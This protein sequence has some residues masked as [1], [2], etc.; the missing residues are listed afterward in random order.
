MKAEALSAAETERLLA[1][2]ATMISAARPYMAAL[3]RAAG[4]DRHAAMLGDARGLVLDVVGDRESVH[5]PEAVPGPGAL[6]AEELGGANGIGTPLAERGYAELVGPEHF[7]GGFHAF[8]CQGAPLHD[9][10]GAIVGVISTSVRRLDASAR[11]REILLCAANGIEA[12][13]LRARLEEDVRRV[14][15][16]SNEALARLRDDV[17]QSFAAARVRLDVAAR[18]AALGGPSYTLALVAEA[19]R[20]IDR[21]RASARLWRDLASDEVGAPTGIALDGTVREVADLLR[22]EAA[23]ARVELA[24]GGVEPVRIVADGRTVLRDVFAAC[25][26][27]IDAA[28]GGGTVHVWTRPDRAG[29]RGV[30]GVET[31]PALGVAGAAPRV[32]R[33]S[34]PLERQGE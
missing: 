30:V 4:S 23:T 2:E 25:V 15:A 21:F 24:L 19:Q 8:T 18:R 34:Y 27:A 28:A 13:L 29:A 20:G 9:P 3:S 32:A 1:R 14:L 33:L 7:I 31:E 22:T 17:I 11:L 10:S 6:L 16:G 12:E 26:S 5:G